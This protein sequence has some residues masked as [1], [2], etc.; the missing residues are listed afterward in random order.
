[1]TGIRYFL[2]GLCLFISTGEV[3]AWRWEPGELQMQ[4]QPAPIDADARY[5]DFDHG[6]DDSAG[7]RQAPWKRHPWDSNARGLSRDS[8]DVH[9]YIFKRGTTYRG[10]LT[11]RDSGTMDQPI[12]LTSDPGWGHGEAVLSG[13]VELSGGWGRCEQSI[14]ERIPAESRPLVWCHALNGHEEPRLL[15]QKSDDKISRIRIARTPNWNITDPDNP[16]SEWYEL[17]DV[18]IELVLGVDGTPGFSRGDR[19]SVRPQRR[20]PPWQKTTD[21]PEIKVL[22]VN[23][24]EM[25][26][27]VRNW[28]KGMLR[29]GDRLSGSMATTHIRS[30][31]GTHSIIRR[32]IDR[33]HLSDRDIHT[34]NGAVVWAERRNMPKPDAAIVAAYDPDEASLSA[35]FHRA[36][37]AGPRP[38]DRYFL[39]GLPEFLDQAGEYAYIPGT[40]QTGQLAMRLLDDKDPDT[41]SIEIANLPVLLAIHDQSHIEVSG[42]RFAHSNQVSA[43]SS[44]ARHAS[45]YASAIQIRGDASFITIRDCNFRN[46]PAGIVAIPKEGA[47]KSTLDRISIDN[48]Q[49]RDIDGSAIALSSGRNHYRLKTSGSRLVHVSV[50]NNTL[51]NV[52]QRTLGQFGV[53]SQGHAIQIDGGEIVEVAGNDVRRSYGSGISVFIGSAFEPGKVERPFLRGLIHHNRVVDSL[54]A[55]Q[56]GG[57]ISSWMGGPTYMFNNE[58]G[59]PVGCMHSR[60]QIV[61]RVNWYRKGC[62][63]VGFYLDGQYKGY[64]FNNIA[65]GKNNNVNDRIYNSVAFNEAMGFMN[66]VFHNTFYRFGVGLHKGMFQ[67]NRNYYLANVFADTGLQQIQQEPRSDTIEYGTLAYSRN[68]F[69]GASPKF[70]SL[71]RPKET[72]HR[73]IASWRKSLKNN[74]AMVFDTGQ[75]ALTGPDFL[76][77]EFRPVEGKLSVDKGVKVF[78]PWAL[79]RV[80]GEWHFRARQDNPEIVSDESLWMTSQWRNRDMFHKIP[81]NNLECASATVVDFRPGVLEDWVD[82]ALQFRSGHISCSASR[83]ELL[84]ISDSRFLI[85]AVVK[86]D[87]GGT[88]IL[89]KRGDR[90]YSLGI[91]SDGKLLFVLDHGDSMIQVESSVSITDGQWHHVLVEIDRSRHRGIDIYIDGKRANG[92]WSGQSMMKGSLGT[93]AG[94]RVGGLPDRGFSGQLDFLRVS[95]G[96]L[97]DAETDIDE[98]YAWQFHGPFLRDRHGFVEGK[99]RD[100]GAVEHRVP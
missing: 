42:L 18:V 3:S 29:K 90:G 22:R 55:A 75:V 46:L 16:R 70:G 65:W 83:P 98:L 19:L 99:Q 72:A 81:R 92:E 7:T 64:V 24:G 49:F 11:A 5:I 21:P 82:G 67:H 68:L 57:G 96:N 80:A 48:S 14:L 93:E 54:L 30:I 13:A 45:M 63:G 88:E 95:R 37:G 6:N 87:H 69:L 34:Y 9:T 94:F 85:E 41:A 40:G 35:N 50:R 77:Q 86:P 38:F 100:V 78:V 44:Q 56:D 51:E 53:G 28:F 52:G 74:Q 31:K 91:K 15:W 43:G 23:Q 17:E 32:L 27:E 2:T 47:G 66:T 33:K 84:D 58:S 73:N 97:S 36:A 1:M 20:R 79:S 12:R 4:R 62:Y 61:T 39:E 71:G 10:Q 25:V 60:Y 59:N 89:S 76:D 8:K 26:V